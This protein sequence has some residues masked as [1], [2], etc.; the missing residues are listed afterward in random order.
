VWDER[1]PGKA[2]G[3][4]VCVNGRLYAISRDGNLMVAT[5]GSKFE[6]LG[7]LSLGEGCQTTPGVAGGR[8]IVRTNTKLIAIGG[9]AP[10]VAKP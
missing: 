5:T 2:Y 6:S 3:S 8:L 7:E 9:A 4:P 1:G 10:S